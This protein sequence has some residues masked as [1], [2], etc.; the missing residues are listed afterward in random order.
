V[1][2]LGLLL[3][4]SAI[5]SAKDRE[6]V[7]HPPSTALPVLHATR[8]VQ[9]PLDE[10]LAGNP[11][12]TYAFLATLD[13]DG[14]PTSLLLLDGDTLFVPEISK[15]LHKEFFD[16]HY[17]NRQVIIEG[18]I[19]QDPTP[20]AK[21]HAQ[22]IV[23]ENVEHPSPADE[24]RLRREETRRASDLE[25]CTP[26]MDSH[27]LA[28]QGNRIESTNRGEAYRC[29]EMA[30]TMAPTSIAALYG[31]SWTCGEKGNFA[32]HRQYLTQIVAQR[33]DYYEARI[34]L[35]ESHPSPQD[36]SL[37]IIELQ[38]ILA[39]N[40]PPPIQLDILGSL[41][42]SAQTAGDSL[43]EVLYRGQWSGIARRYFALYPKEFDADYSRTSI[44]SN[45]E[46]LALNLEGMHRWAE[47]E[48]VYRRNLS[49]IAVDP[50][51]EKEV[52]FDQELGLSRTLA[53]QGKTKDAAKIC[54]RWKSSAKFIAGQNA[55]YWAYASRPAE[56]AKWELSCGKEQEGLVRLN[57]ESIA[58]PKGYATYIAL[59]DYYY[60]HGDVK[61]ALKAEEQNRKA[62][63]LATSQTDW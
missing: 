22:I 32:C 42:S 21:P 12:W 3:L 51:F 44:V 7:S 8:Q 6:K 18:S 34:N 13:S 27:S 53:A 57:E 40:P 35:A 31:A 23:L 26:S 25:H 52:K 33:P 29:F 2:A 10:L 48:E 54:S 39:D 50:L 59:R 45:D 37:T 60:A 49:L 47:A 63:D 15:A 16:I 56:I 36:D 30:L 9:I 38:K 4:T 46:P 5:S 43:D 55:A 1:L 58:H 11:G 19:P 17:A 61:S 24:E 20:L 14:H 62:N 41:A 28:R